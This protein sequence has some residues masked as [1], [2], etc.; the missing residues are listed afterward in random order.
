MHVTMFR[1]YGLLV[2]EDA[3]PADFEVEALR[4][5]VMARFK[6]C[7]EALLLKVGWESCKGGWDKHL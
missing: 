5:A 1:Q 4:E 7:L 3:L 6:N 2:L